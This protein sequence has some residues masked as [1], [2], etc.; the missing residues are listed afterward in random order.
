[1]VNG[2]KVEFTEEEYLQFEIDCK[3][4]EDFKLK[5]EYKELRAK[6][7]GS[8]VEQLDMM[9]HSGF[10]AWKAHIAEVKAM[11]PKPSGN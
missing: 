10:D 11:Y 3:E 4:F 8:L 7:Y 1:M 5:N 2:V 6:E 9:Y